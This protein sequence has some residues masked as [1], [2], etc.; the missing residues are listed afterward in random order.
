MPRSPR[1]TPGR[2]RSTARAEWRRAATRSPTSRTCSFAGARSRVVGSAARAMIAAVV[3][4]AGAGSRFG[5]PK[6]RL[7]VPEVLRSLRAAGLER[8]VV[9]AGAH[10][11][12]VDADVVDCPDWEAGPGVSLRCGLAALGDDVD[13]ALVVLGDGPDLDP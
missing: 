9:V 7:L 2:L 8:I 13:A 1:T 10:E 4:A 6:Q 11:L 3:L 12:D 5:G